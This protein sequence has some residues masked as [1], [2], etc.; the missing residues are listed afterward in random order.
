MAPFS[1]REINF[2][3][4]YIHDDKKGF[5]GKED[6]VHSPPALPA[7]CTQP[8][9]C[10]WSRGAVHSSSQM[11]PPHPSSTLTSQELPQLPQDLTTELTVQPWDLKDQRQKFTFWYEDCSFLL[12]NCC[13]S[14]PIK[15]GLSELL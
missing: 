5:N 14:F 4:G 7:P 11:H 2:Y 3:L 9:L 13:V 10:P 12:Q 8:S 6:D 1:I 15:I